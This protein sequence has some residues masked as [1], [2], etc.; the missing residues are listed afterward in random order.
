MVQRT[1]FI[2]KP[3][4]IRRKLISSILKDIRSSG[5][6]ILTQKKISLSH[7]TLELL[8]GMHKG[9]DFYDNLIKYMSSG[10][11]VCAVVEGV[12]SVERLRDL[13]GDTYPS[14][15]SPES[16]RGKYKMDSDT[17]P[18]GAIENMVHGSDGEKQAKFEIELIFGKEWAV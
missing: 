3:D 5:L 15:A 6:K 18:S 2:I 9:K 14:G 10:P 1:L 13:M 11:C 8:Y 7:G 16:I 4:A 17:G 12:N